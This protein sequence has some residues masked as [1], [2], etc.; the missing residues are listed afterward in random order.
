MVFGGILILT[1]RGLRKKHAVQSGL[2]IPN[3]YLL[4]GQQN[5]TGNVDRL[6]RPSDF[7]VRT[8]VCL[9]LLRRTLMVLAMCFRIILHLLHVVCY[10]A[11]QE[12]I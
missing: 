6:G 2:R 4:E 7:L 11:V 1:L 8:V 3:Q 10:L 9:Q 12:S 5:V